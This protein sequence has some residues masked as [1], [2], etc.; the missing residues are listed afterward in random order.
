M[1]EKLREIAD[2]INYLSV[3]TDSVLNATV[4]DDGSNVKIENNNNPD[5]EIVLIATENQLLSITPLFSVASVTPSR[6]AELD[7]A[8]L[9]ISLPMVLSSVSI[10]NDDRYVLFG[11]MAIN[12]TIENLVYELE[13]QASNY[14]E[15]MA[16]LAEFIVEA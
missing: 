16:A 6:V 10:Q 8:L 4:S 5:V 2:Q 3:K 7:R 13:V 14:D 12:T 9:A 11:S 1:N 15:L